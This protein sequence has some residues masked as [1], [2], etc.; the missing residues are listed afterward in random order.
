MASKGI[1]APPELVP[2]KYASWRKAMAIWEMATTLEKKKRAPVVFLSLSGKAQEAILELDPTVLSAD[3][4][5][6]KLYDKLDS[7]FKI[8]SAQAALSAYADFEKY[9]RPSSMSMADFNVEYDRMVQKLKEHDI[10]LPEAVLAHRVLKSANLSEDNEKLVVATVKDATYTDMMD[11]IRKIMRVRPVDRDVTVKPVVA[12]IKSEPLDINL[13]ESDSNP[14]NESREEDSEVHYSNYRGRGW[15]GNSR[16]GDWRGNRGSNRGAS[17]RSRRGQNPM[18]YDG[19]VSKCRICGSTM[20]WARDCQHKKDKQKDAE[21]DNFETSIVLLNQEKSLDSMLL[22][23][24]IGSIVLDSGC[25]KTV[26][27]QTWYQCYI[28]TLPGRL[29]K[30]LKCENSK[31]S[32]RFGNGKVLNSQ[33]KVSLPCRLAGKDIEISTDVIDSDIPLLLSKDSMKKAGTVMN[34]MEDS[35]SILGTDVKLNCSQSG[36]YYMPLSRVTGVSNDP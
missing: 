31:A 5:L 34:F 36:H 16:R 9:T 29:K 33:F 10:K 7:L 23:E 22:G 26:C 18:G 11:Q 20:H 28:D 21:E 6:D 25:C 1:Y 12:T 15:R 2:E 14:S 27:G 4:G 13:A 19:K 32:F 17:F 8:D 24:T 3:D 30:N 35:V